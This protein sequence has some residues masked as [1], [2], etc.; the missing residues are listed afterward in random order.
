MTAADLLTAAQFYGYAGL[1]VAAVFLTVG[2]GRVD[3]G[4]RG[5]Y[6]ARLL[7]APSVILLWPVVLVRWAQLERR[8]GGDGA[9]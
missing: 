8:A 2:V 9:P 3:A 1:A 4:A 5:A 7:L 6:A